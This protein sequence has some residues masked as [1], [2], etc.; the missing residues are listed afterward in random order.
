MKDAE[1]HHQ[2]YIHI[3]CTPA[4]P[5]EYQRSIMIL[6]IEYVLLLSL[7]ACSS[8]IRWRM[9]MDMNAAMVF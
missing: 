4:Q 1:R 7:A 5:S 6:L 9:G 2:K 3:P 8:W